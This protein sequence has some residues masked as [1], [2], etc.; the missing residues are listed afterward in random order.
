M[1]SGLSSAEIARDLGVA[2]S[3]IARA[4]DKVEKEL[5]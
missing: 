5:T 4:I 3:S 1:D 2:T